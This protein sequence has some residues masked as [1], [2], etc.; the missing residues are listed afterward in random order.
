[1]RLF[2]KKYDGLSDTEKSERF[3]SCNRYL[4]MIENAGT[5]MEL[6]DIHK[7][8][9]GQ[10]LQHEKYGPGNMFRTDNIST[11]RP[12]H[13]ML[14]NI[15]GLWTNPIPFW[16]SR[17][18]EHGVDEDYQAVFNQYRRVLDSNLRQLRAF[19][20]DHGFNRAKI[21]DRIAKTPEAVAAG[22]EKLMISDKGLDQG[23]LHTMEFYAAGERRTSSMY[24]TLSQ[25][26]TD[27]RSFTLVPNG[28]EKGVRIS[29]TKD[30][31][32]GNPWT[33]VFTG[34]KYVIAA[35]MNKTTAQEQSQERT[36][37]MKI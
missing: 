26:P 5:L 15:N 21:E 35:K 14:G 4:E 33:D 37:Q 20:Y 36:R 24:L 9:W 30:M 19:V 1:M 18:R 11:M 16:E 7:E 3:A 6:Y 32:K 27:V 34:K 31:A 29:R 13:V 22:V 8:M 10:G 17:R 25:S 12:E 23:Q 2:T 28:W